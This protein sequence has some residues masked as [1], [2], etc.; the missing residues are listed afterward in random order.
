VNLGEI[1][2]E[3]PVLVRYAYLN[4]G[5]FG[6]LPRRTAEA[7]TAWQCRSLE[8]PRASF[9][10]FQEIL[11]VRTRLRQAIARL[12]GAEPETLAL[13]TSTTEG[14]NTVVAGLRLKP[15]DEVVTTDSEHP[16]LLG[17]LRAWEL[18]LR[19]APVS[20]VPPSEALSAIEREV[21][22]RTRL[23]ALSHV[24]WTTG[25]VLP[26]RDLARLG[27]PLLVDG[28]QSAGTIPVDVAGLGCDFF[29]VSGQKWLLG[30]DATGALYVRRD[31]IEELKQTF[32]SYVAWEDP[33]K[34]VPWPDARRFESVF[35]PSAS[36]AG[37]LASLAFAE[38][39]GEGRFAHAREAANRCRE[40][41][42]EQAEIVTEPGQ[43]TLVTWRAEDAEEQVKRLW[44]GGVVVRNFS[45]LPYVRASCGFWTSDEDLERLVRGL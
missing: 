38:E 1:R 12:I 27:P 23:V 17:A 44:E 34:L 15:G 28:A 20:E 25:H 36:A 11:E 31:R 29:T 39:A 40:L 4:T 22:P 42:A 18:E 5:T 9:A 26:I 35:T 2:A 43:A 8:E 32:P 41:V 7:M 33:A 14:C 45:G 24:L 3:L 16:G 6:P 13:T 30:P 10:L 19:I 37:L 21:T